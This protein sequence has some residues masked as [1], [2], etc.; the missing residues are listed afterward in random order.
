[1]RI[2]RIFL[3][4][5]I[6]AI[7]V[8]GPY[9]FYQFRKAQFRNFHVVKE[10]V[11]YRSGQMTQDG[12][13]R[14]VYD[15]SIKT[16]ISLRF[17]SNPKDAPP[18]VFEEGLSRS[19]GMNHFR[20]PYRSWH[21]VHGSIPADKGVNKFLKIMRDP[22][23][24][25]VLIHCFAGIHRTGAYCAIFRIEFDHWSNEQAMAEMKAYGYVMEHPDVFAY[26]QNYRPPSPSH[27]EP[28]L[29]NPV[30]RPASHE[31]EVEN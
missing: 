29:A 6:V 11:L 18:D 25:P 8:A 1:M 15:H 28:P 9:Y 21:S 4:L 7:I 19:M 5:A 10:G 27:A 26:L 2:V 12:F 17:A 13:Q 14:M 23:N 16:V 20:I 22:A 30:V 31:L 3:G 24:Y